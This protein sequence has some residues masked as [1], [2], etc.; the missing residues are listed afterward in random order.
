MRKLTRVRRDRLDGE[1][2]RSQCEEDAQ[3]DDG[4]KTAL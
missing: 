2:R 3:D 4:G 1:H